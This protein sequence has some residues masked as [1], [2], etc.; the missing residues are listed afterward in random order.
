MTAHRKRLGELVLRSEHAPTLVEFYLNIIGLEPYA[1]AGSATFLKIDDAAEGH[2]QLLAIFDKSHDFYGPRSINANK[3]DSK[4]G[5]LHHFAFMIDL[6][7][8]DSERDRLQRTGIDLHLE[9]FPAFGW[10]SIFMQDPD[11]NS[12]ELVCYDA[13]TLDEAAH[14][15]VR[16]S[17]K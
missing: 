16:Q 10:R 8:F 13:T 4:A 14:Q 5:T 15:R 7:D 3:A 1:T 6:K 9:E 2:P 17:I 11:G 12:V